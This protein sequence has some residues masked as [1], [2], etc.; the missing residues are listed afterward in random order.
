MYIL[1]F[2]SI[3]IHFPNLSKSILIYLN[4]Y[5]C[6]VAAKFG[7]PSQPPYLSLYMTDDAILHGV[8][9]ASGGAGILNETGIYFVSIV[10]L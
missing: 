10:F 5:F 7:V 3:L 1:I 2:G 9:F 8:N 4:L 6:N